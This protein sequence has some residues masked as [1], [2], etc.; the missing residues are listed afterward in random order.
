MVAQGE[1]M[2]T[3]LGHPARLKS[4]KFTIPFVGELE[5]EPD[6]SQRR[7]AWELYVELAT[8][9][10]V[11]PIDLDEGTVREALGSLHALFATTRDILRRAG[12]DVGA[13]RNTVGG[14]AIMVLNSGIRP[15]LSKWHPRL[16][17]HEALRP[18]GRSPREWE[19]EWRCEADLRGELEQLSRRLGEYAR[20]LADMAGLSL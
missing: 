16:L 14:V 3:A 5:W 12:P 8:R 19:R 15:F 4:F 20:V 17:A 18:P 2:T 6:P 7:A 1:S 11:Q 13:G 9:I 10:A